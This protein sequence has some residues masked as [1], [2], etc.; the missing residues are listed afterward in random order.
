MTS[1]VSLPLWLMLIVGALALWSVLDR[2]VDP[3]RALPDAAPLQ[4]RDR[5][6]QHAAQAAHPAVQARQAPGADRPAHLRPGSAARGRGVCGR[7]Q[8]AARGRAA[9]RASLRQRD[10]A[11]VLGL[12]VFRHRHA[13]RAPHLD[14]SLSRAPRLH[15][16]ERDADGRSRRGGDLRDQSPLQHG[17]CAGHLHGVDLVGAELRGRRVGAGVAAAEPDPLDGRL[18]R[19]P[20]LAR[21]A[22]SQGAVALRPSRGRGRADPGDVPGRRPDARRQAAPAEARPAELHGVGVR[23][24]GP[25]R[26]G[27]RARRHQLRP[28]D[29]GPR[30]GRRADD[31]GGREAA[32][33][34]QPEGAVRLSGA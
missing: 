20:R 6:P 7:Q 28:R 10:R 31:A 1:Q 16:R 4:P 25:A 21:A 26:R 34:V 13:A 19:A 9:A 22:L 3:G 29:R 14:L 15:G 8:G 11:V 24:E 32:L 23:S 30:A 18:F 17:L 27:V 2:A 5:G 12:C 33:Q